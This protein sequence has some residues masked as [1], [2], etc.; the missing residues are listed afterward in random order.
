MRLLDF[1]NRIEMRTASVGHY[2]MS[3]FRVAKTRNAL[4]ISAILRNLF[5][6]DLNEPPLL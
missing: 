1:L 5:A 3:L 6:V 2:S 4:V